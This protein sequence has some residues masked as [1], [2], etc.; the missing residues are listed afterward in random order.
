MKRTYVDTGVLIAAA[1]GSGRLFDRAFT[2]LTDPN[3]EFVSRD[4]VRFEIIP[5][6]TYFS[7][8]SEIRFYEEFFSL[9]AT[10]CPFNK[11]DLDAAFKEACLSGLG[12]LDSVHVVLAA[13]TGCEELVTSEKVEKSI[14]R[15]KLVKVVTIDTD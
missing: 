2:I 3:R 5:K 4:Y 14:H 15:T 10:W 12:P 8:E 6:P 1:R 13:Q 11:S 9:A 7:R